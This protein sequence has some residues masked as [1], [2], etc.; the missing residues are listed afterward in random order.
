VTV[1]KSGDGLRD[2]H[3]E[4]KGP[5]GL[6]TTTTATSLHPENETRLLSLTISDSPHQ[7]KAIM[8]AIAEGTQPGIDLREWHELQEWLAADPLPV[9]IPWAP[10]LAEAIPPVT[11]RLR[12]DFP[13]VLALIEEHAQLHRLSRPRTPEGW[14]VVTFDDYEV[15][16][17]LVGDL[18]AEAAERTVPVTVR[19]T[20]EHVRGLTAPDVGEAT[21]VAI[22]QS[23]G[24]DKSAASR[25]VKVAPERGYLTNAED[26]GGRPARL[27]LG[28]P[29]PNEYTVLPVRSEL[30]RLH[31]CRLE[32]KKAEQPDVLPDLRAEARRIFG[33]MLMD[34][35]MTGD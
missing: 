3:I 10:T 35:D 30:E 11:T 5:T 16:R 22:A 20:V 18:V 8:V 1:E 26:H 6:L 13:T 25:R 9:T 23:L 24:I 4:R 33:D 17:D 19:E 14:V 32:P 7:T 31:E 2:R 15:V 28:E 21:V 12:R 27:R 34:A 29:L